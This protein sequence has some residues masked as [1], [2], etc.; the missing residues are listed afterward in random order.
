V[1]QK[2]AEVREQ[3][4]KEAMAEFE[5]KHLQVTWER[6]REIAQD[7][8][9][10]ASAEDDVPE[11]LA[12]YASD[13]RNI[14]IAENIILRKGMTSNEDGQKALAQLALRADKEDPNIIM[15]VIS[16]LDN[17]LGLTSLYDKKIPDP[18]L[19]VMGG[20]QEQDAPMLT[21]DGDRVLIDDLKGIDFNNLFD[22]GKALRFK[23][24]P[25]A[26]KDEDAAVQRMVLK[27]LK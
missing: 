4:I 21:L 6:R 7:L 9:K 18:V 17:M 2:V 3:T 11:T 16:K 1:I 25:E 10:R 23:H 19:T 8:T 26:L 24:K 14:K 20:G 22:A 27:E 15:K 13:K 12:K 5:E